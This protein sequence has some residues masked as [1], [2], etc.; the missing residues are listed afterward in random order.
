MEIITE[1]HK[2]EVRDD[3]LMFIWPVKKPVLRQMQSTPDGGID[4]SF[5]DESSSDDSL[6]KLVTA[7]GRVPTAVVA[8]GGEDD[9]HCDIDAGFQRWTGTKNTREVRIALKNCGLETNNIRKV[10]KECRKTKYNYL[11]WRA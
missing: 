3:G 8:F 7:M 9:W 10:L 5:H 2:V 6:K 1:T 4:V 11:P